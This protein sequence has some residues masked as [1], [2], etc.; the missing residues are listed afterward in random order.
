MR[1]S[2]YRALA[3]AWVAGWV[4]LGPSMALAA[5]NTSDAPDADVRLVQYPIKVFADGSLALVWLL[6]IVLMLVCLAG[7]FKS[8]K[9]THLD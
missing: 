5:N 4:A 2:L 6:G 9:R 8:A 3:A 7:L 1:R